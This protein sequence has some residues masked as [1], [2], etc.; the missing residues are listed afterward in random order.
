MNIQSH[1][2]WISLCHTFDL[3][4][5][6]SINMRAHAG[7][8]SVIALLVNVAET[9]AGSAP[10]LSHKSAKCFTEHRICVRHTVRDE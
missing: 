2:V 7:G 1:L 9:A 6:E 10:F 8:H 3:L 4:L 5:K